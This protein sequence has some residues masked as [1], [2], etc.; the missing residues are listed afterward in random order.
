MTIMEDFPLVQEFLKNDAFG[1]GHFAKELKFSN[2]IVPALE[3]FL[4]LKKVTGF[5]KKL[6]ELTKKPCG[7]D[8]RNAKRVQWASL[9]AELGAIC[10]LGKTLNFRIVGFDRHSSQAPKSD[11]DCD[12]VAMVNGHLTFVEVKR[13]ASED[14]QMLPKLLEDRLYKLALPFNITV[15]LLNAEYNCSDLDTRL[16]EIKHRVES[17]VSMNVI[18]QSMEE[19]C[20]ASFLSD[21]FE[22]HFHVKTGSTM[23][24]FTQYSPAFTEDLKPY[25]VGPSTIGKK[26]K[27]MT[28]MVNQALEK[29]AHYL[30][31]RVPGWQTWQEIVE[32]CFGFVTYTNGRTYFTADPGLRDLRGIVLFTR[33]DSFCIVN[34]LNSGAG[35][36]LIA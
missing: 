18:G 33:Y 34:N 31:C 20:P 4:S 15:N 16:A 14:T 21:D 26:G 24:Q 25:L 30:F 28:P 3:Y 1:T 8:N 23:K 22:V 2:P 35:A 29:G 13:R 9:C 6:E 27:P 32:E 11:N 36:W 19:P 17:F 10:L 12:I 5:S 7:T